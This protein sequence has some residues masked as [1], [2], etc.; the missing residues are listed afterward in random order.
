MLTTADF[1][2][3][4]G[5]VPMAQAAG[6]MVEKN[7]RGASFYVPKTEKTALRNPGASSRFTKKLRI[8][9]EEHGGGDEEINQFFWRWGG[10]EF[11]L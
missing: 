11:R 3:L 7:W 6:V 1:V 4:W 2:D 10:M 9:V 8:V 5:D